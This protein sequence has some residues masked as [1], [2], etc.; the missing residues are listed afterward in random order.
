MVSLFEKNHKRET[1]VMGMQ[2]TIRWFQQLPDHHFY[3]KNLSHRCTQKHTCEH[4]YTWLHKDCT[5]KYT[6]AICAMCMMH[7]AA[8][9]CNTDE[10]WPTTLA[11]LSW[12]IFSWFVSSD[13]SSYSDDVLLY[14]RRPF[15]Q[16][17]TQSID[18]IDVASVTLSRLNSINA[19]YVTR[20]TLSRWR[21]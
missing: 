10:F 14:I 19:I 5:N 8:Y 3:P 15:F 2:K 18:A 4:R 1:L 12:L 17:F 13:R 21:A 9:R 7:T 6:D 11:F 20:V 16:I